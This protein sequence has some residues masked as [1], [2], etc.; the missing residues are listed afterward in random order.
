MH[1]VPWHV[2]IIVSDLSISVPWYET[3]LGFHEVRRSRADALGAQ[4]SFL[5]RGDF[6][7]ELFQYD[8]PNAL[9]EVRRQPNTD[10]RTLG[11]KHLAFRVDDLSAM[12]GEMEKACCFAGD[13]VLEKHF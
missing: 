9:P 11:T 5:A 7:L 6:E 4:L 12:L 13:P 1:I 10:L 2:G 3:V 8:N